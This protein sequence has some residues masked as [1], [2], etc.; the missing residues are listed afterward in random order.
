MRD[1]ERWDGWSL[2]VGWQRKKTP[3]CGVEGWFATFEPTF[4]NMTSAHSS[5]LSLTVSS[6]STAYMVP[7]Y[8]IVRIHMHE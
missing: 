3:K 1:D 8:F 2:F 7:Y 5:Q 6:L 4:F